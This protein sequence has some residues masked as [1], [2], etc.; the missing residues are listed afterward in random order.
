MSAVQPIDDLDLLQNQD[1]SY[2]AGKR[3]RNS[4]ATQANQAFTTLQAKETVPLVGPSPNHFLM[5][6]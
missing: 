4:L 3:A 5:L 2:G 6:N 1:I